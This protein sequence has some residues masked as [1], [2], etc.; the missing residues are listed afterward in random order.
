MKQVYQIVQVRNAEKVDRHSHCEEG[1]VHTLQTT[2]SKM[3]AIA[4]A[5]KGWDTKVYT[6]PDWKEVTATIQVTKVSE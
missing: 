2:E 4:C 6:I 5:E 3:V 1:Y